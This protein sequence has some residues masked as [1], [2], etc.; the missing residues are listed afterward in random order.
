MQLGELLARRL[1]RVDVGA[2][3]LAV[4]PE[5]GQDRHRFGVVTR[6]GRTVAGLSR[7]TV[8]RPD[9]RPAAERDYS[10]AAAILTALRDAGEIEGTDIGTLDATRKKLEDLRA[11]R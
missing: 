4:V 5:R 1:E 2:F 9:D 3:D 11:A 7:Q 8:A 6:R 10:D